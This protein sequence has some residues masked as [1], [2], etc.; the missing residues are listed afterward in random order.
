MWVV[1][2]NTVMTTIDLIKWRVLFGNR[3][4]SNAAFFSSSAGAKLKRDALKL[5]SLA[6]CSLVRHSLGILNSPIYVTYSSHTEKS[7]TL[8][9]TRFLRKLIISCYPSAS[10]LSRE[11]RS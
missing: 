9:L 1:L 11:R 3:F 4:W 5:K 8:I 2:R 6:F 10:G 7:E